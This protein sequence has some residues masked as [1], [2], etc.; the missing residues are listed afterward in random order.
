MKYI[1]SFTLLI[2]SAVICASGSVWA[3]MPDMRD[4]ASPSTG[5]LANSQWVSG[6]VEKIETIGEYQYIRVNGIQYRMMPNVDIARRVSRGM[7]AYDEVT[8]SVKAIREN[9]DVMLRV[10]G[11]RI[12]QILIME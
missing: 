12:Y 11:F 8:A 7:D 2:L 6:K 3:E 5:Y 4:T 9:T 1:C 10:Q